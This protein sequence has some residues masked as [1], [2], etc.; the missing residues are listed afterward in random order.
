MKYL[1]AMALS[2]FLLALQPTKAQV[3]AGDN[4][5]T[6]LCQITEFHHDGR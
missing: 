6:I 2:L 5:G 1:F 4:P 3:K